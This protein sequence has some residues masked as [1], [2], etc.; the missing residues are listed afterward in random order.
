[1]VGDG[2]LQLFRSWNGNFGVESKISRNHCSVRIIIIY[3]FLQENYFLAI[4]LIHNRSY[5]L[6]SFKLKLKMGRKLLKK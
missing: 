4:C 2:T 5:I 6:N 3:F 1:M